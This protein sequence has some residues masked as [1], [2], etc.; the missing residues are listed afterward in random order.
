MDHFITRPAPNAV[1]AP[2]DASPDRVRQLITMIQANTRKDSSRYGRATRAE[3][4]SMLGVSLNQLNNWSRGR[5][6]GRTVGSERDRRAPYA[7]IYCLE[8]LAFTPGATY[9]T[10]WSNLR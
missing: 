2:L 8:A 3:I 5:T 1:A 7:V 10:Y 9:K 6:R 4:A